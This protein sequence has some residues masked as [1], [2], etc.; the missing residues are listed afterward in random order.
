MPRAVHAAEDGA[1]MLHAVADDA[2]AAMRADGG[3]RRNRAFERVE[4][5]GASAHVDLEALVV[6]VAALRA[7]AHGSLLM[8]VYRAKSR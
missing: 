1:V 4:G 8:L 3:K 2:R 6:V 7:L 5:E